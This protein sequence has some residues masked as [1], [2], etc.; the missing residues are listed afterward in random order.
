MNPAAFDVRD[1]PDH[2]SCISCHRQQF[3]RGARPAI[4]SNCHTVVSPRGDARLPFPNPRAASQFE[5]TFPHASHVK[6]TSLIQ[7]RRLTAPAANLQ[8]T[9]TYCHKVNNTEFKPAAGSP[10]DAYVPAAGTF[11]TTPS[12][13][14][15]CFACH[16]EK[17]VENREQPPLANECAK[18]HSLVAPPA[19]ATA[20]AGAGA[21][22]TAPA[23][24]SAHGAPGQAWPV[25]VV[26]KFPHETDA[27]KKRTNDDGKETPITCVQ[28]HTAVRRAATLADLRREGQVQLPTCSSSAC[29]TAVSGTAQLRLSLYREL[30][31]RGKDAKFECALCHTPPQSLAQV[32]CGHYAAVYAKVK[33]EA[34]KRAKPG[35][36][37]AEV[38]RRTRGIMN[39]T[40]EQ[41]K[42]ELK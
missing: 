15:T 13:H 42:G 2:D 5:L 16:Y 36:E 17:G 11:M 31:A 1:Y 27:H 35:E 23:A 14:Q 6:S 10:A 28:C 25:R 24:V 41:C 19:T 32:P 3:F 39:L 30:G 37:D 29:H 18:C 7:F 12:S 40:P 38:E 34:R 26:Q 9:C 20:A 33:E 8:A 4:C 22:R 21:Q